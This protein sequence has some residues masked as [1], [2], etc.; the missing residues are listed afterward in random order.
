MKLLCGDMLEQLSEVE[1]LSVDLL[2]TDP[3]YN[4]SN[5]AA[6][7]D[8]IDPVTGKNKNTI[9]DQKFDENFSNEWDSFTDVEFKELLTLWA[10]AWLS[11]TIIPPPPVV[12]T[13][14]PLKLKQPRSPNEPA[15]LFL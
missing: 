10:N 11:V 12:I 6:R 14:F 4:I 1:D 15:C 5:N 8:W 13:L 9:H 3:P 7:P 2:L